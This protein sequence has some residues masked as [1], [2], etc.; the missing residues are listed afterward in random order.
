VLGICQGVQVIAV[1]LDGTLVG[2]LPAAGRPG[3]WEEEPAR[4]GAS[5]HFH[6]AEGALGGA[7]TV[8]SIHHQAVASVGP[9][10][11]A[12][13]WGPGI[14]SFEAQGSSVSSGTRSGC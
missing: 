12:T 10:L 9:S 8:S 4:G 3:H 1:A 13:A 5:G 11:V 7:G 6:P 14:I 2:D